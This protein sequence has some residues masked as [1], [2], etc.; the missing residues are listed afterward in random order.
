M[1]KLSRQSMPKIDDSE[2]HYQE[3]KIKNKSAQE[4]YERFIEDQMESTF[5]EVV[6]IIKQFTYRER[7]NVLSDQSLKT[8]PTIALTISPFCS[9]SA[10]ITLSRLTC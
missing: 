8:I 5:D 3:W 9:Y 7:V 4:N 10:L 2:R 1:E 6:K